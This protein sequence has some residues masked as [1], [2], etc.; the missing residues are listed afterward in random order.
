MYTLLY[1]SLLLITYLLVCSDTIM[2]TIH[3]DRAL[4]KSSFKS[5]FLRIIKCVLMIGVKRRQ[6]VVYYDNQESLRSILL[7]HSFYWSP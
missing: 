4:A 5:F 6:L 3:T 7:I 2:C 1:I